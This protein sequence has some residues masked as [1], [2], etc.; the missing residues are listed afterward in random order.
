MLYMF[1]HVKFSYTDQ[2]NENLNTKSIVILELSPVLILYFSPLVHTAK[3]HHSATILGIFSMKKFKH[4]H[5]YIYLNNFHLQ[6]EAR[7]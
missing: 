3:S 1:L 5:T 6:S 7:T 2:Y 4:T